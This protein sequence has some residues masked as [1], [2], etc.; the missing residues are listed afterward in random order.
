MMKQAPWRE[1]ATISVLAVLV[2]VGAASGDH[3]AG[4]LLRDYTPRNDEGWERRDVELILSVYAPDAVQ[5]AWHEPD[6][7]TSGRSRVVRVAG[8]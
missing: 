6:R 1:F 3:G 8:G 5:R 7:M 2:A 4:V